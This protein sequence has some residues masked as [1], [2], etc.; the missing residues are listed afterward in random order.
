MCSSWGSRRSKPCPHGISSFTE[1]VNTSLLC[2]HPSG[3][4]ILTTMV[5]LRT[6]PVAPCLEV[7]R[8]RL[9]GAPQLSFPSRWGG[10]FVTNPVILRNRLF[11]AYCLSRTGRCTQIRSFWFNYSESTRGVD[12]HSSDFTVDKPKALDCGPHSSPGCLYMSYT[13]LQTL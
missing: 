2:A 8:L 5:L 4:T 9:I 7:R 13:R 6:S 12:R 10:C 3:E 1:S 11:E